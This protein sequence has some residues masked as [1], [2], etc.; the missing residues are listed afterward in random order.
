MIK[1]LHSSVR[2]GQAIRLARQQASRNFSVE[3]ATS[4]DDKGKLL[5]KSP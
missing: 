2:H 3:I 1:I 5:Q 4:S